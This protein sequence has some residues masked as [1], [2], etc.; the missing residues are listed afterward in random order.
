MYG[1]IMDLQRADFSLADPLLADLALP[2]IDRDHPHCQYLACWRQGSLLALGGLEMY[3]KDGLLRS[4]AVAKDFQGTRIGTHML[5]RLL[6]RSRTLG[7]QQTFLLTT[8][9]AAFFAR[10]GFQTIPRS[11]V[12]AA[13]AASSQ[14]AS[15]CPASATCMVLKAT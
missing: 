5:H 1:L 15:V 4:L 2:A 14:F 7:L 3:Q 11:E 10:M 6:Q 13:I 8:T 12:P 9:A